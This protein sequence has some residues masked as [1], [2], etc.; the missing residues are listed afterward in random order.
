[1]DGW[2]GGWM[3]GRW[4]GG[5]MDAE[6]MDRWMDGW[7]G[8]WKPMAILRKPIILTMEIPWVFHGILMSF[9]WPYS[10]TPE[11]IPCI[12]HGFPWIFHRIYNEAMV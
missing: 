10:K 7:L 12:D 6:W 2:V 4:M 9:L 5:W 8:G 3:Y 1:M 11:K